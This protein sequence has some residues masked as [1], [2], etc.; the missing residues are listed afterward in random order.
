MHECDASAAC[1]REWFCGSRRCMLGP[2][3]AAPHPRSRAATAALAAAAAVGLKLPEDGRRSVDEAGARL[4]PETLPGQ[5]RAGEAPSGVAPAGEASEVVGG[6][7]PL[8]VQAPGLQCLSSRAR[9][10]WNRQRPRAPPRAQP[11][12]PR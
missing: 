10:G 9:A 4:R 2:Q 6:G 7:V 5:E 1:T 8:G 3:V 11:T 12:R